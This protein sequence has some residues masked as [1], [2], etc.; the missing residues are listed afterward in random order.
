MRRLA[1]FS[2][3]WFRRQVRAIGFDH[4]TIERQLCRD[5]A[6]GAAV[7]KRHDS[8][9][10]YEMT[11]REH[12][13]CLFACAAETVKDAAQLA[14]IRAHNVERVLPCVALMNHHVQPQLNREVEL[15]LE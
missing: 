9:E 14:A 2:A 6:H 1:P 7:L 4:E 8:G 13:V 5:V 10:R 11:E 15:L 3:K 12:F